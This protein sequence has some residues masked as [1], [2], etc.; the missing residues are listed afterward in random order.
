MPAS[1]SRLPIGTVTFLFTDI[2]GSTRVLTTLGG[3]S[4]RVV[5]A[6]HAAILR[7]AIGSNAGTEVSTE[8]DAFFAVFRSAVDA[9]NAALAAQRGL[10]EAAWPPGGTIRVRMGLDTGIGALGADDYVGLD[11]HRAAR[12][13]AAGHGGQV[14]M[15]DATRALVAEGLPGGVNVRDLGEHR[16]KDF[17]RPVR[18]FQ[19]DIDG[20]PT[21]FPALKTLDARGG[22]LPAQLTSFVGRDRELSGLIELLRA[23]RLVTLTGAGG[24]GRHAW[25]SRRLDG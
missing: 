11:V 22:N 20:L 8:G 25:R 7:D 19:L 3:D 21:E 24:S 1:S 12:I 4:Y 13:A 9:V 10:F 5:L 14:L 6:T 17:E 2:E 23:H 18:L 16:L 15:S